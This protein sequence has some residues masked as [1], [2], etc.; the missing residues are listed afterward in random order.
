MTKSRLLPLFLALTLIGALSF[1]ATAVAAKPTAAAPAG[2]GLTVPINLPGTIA[3]VAGA[4]DGTLTITKFALKDGQVLANGVLNGVV[5]QAGQTVGTL[6][7]FKVNLPLAP[8]APAA[9]N[10]LNLVLGPL[11]LNLLGLVVDLNQVVL[12]ITAQPGPGNLLGNLLCSVA[13]LLDG[14]LGGGL[15]GI[16]NNLLKAI[17]G[18]LKL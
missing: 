16:L 4:F 12:N 7:N 18:I 13:G 5:T 10:I 1:S 2:A 15:T 9:C 17:N 3:G 14:G 11:H 6:T 8:L